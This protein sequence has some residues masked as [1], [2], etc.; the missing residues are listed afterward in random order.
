MPP[1]KEQHHCPA[2]TTLHVI[3]GRWKIPILFFLCTG[4]KRFGELR[5]SLSGVSPKVLTEHLRQ[6]ET[7]GLISRTI[8]AEVPPRVEYAL[9][10]RG[11]SLQPVVDAMV[12]WG[13]AHAKK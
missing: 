2:E 10:P 13:K 8:H 7:D 6:M 5:T 1:S 12:K 11:R 9:T 4:T 3:G